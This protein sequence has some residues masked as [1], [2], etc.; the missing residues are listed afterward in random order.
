MPT[1]PARRAPLDPAAFAAA[2]AAWMSDHH[3]TQADAAERLAV[4]QSRVS[5]WLRGTSLPS[6]A[7]AGRILPLLGVSPESLRAGSL[8]PRTDDVVMVPRESPVGAAGRLFP[9][10]SDEPTADPYPAAELQRLIGF[11]PRLLVTAVVVGDSIKNIVLPGTRVMYVPTP[12]IADHGL[13]VLDLDGARIIKFVQRLGGDVLALIPANDRYRTETFEPCS[14]ADTP[15]TYRSDLSGRT[16][17]LDVV[18]RVVWFPTL[19]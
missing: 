12:V 13:Y 17:T 4:D 2:L 9:V 14:D 5:V 11:D 19:A 18:G 7:V 1:R 10:P 6:A 8:A 3:L 16:A 15:N